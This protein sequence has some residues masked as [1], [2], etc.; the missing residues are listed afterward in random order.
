M[1]TTTKKPSSRAKTKTSKAKANKSTNSSKRSSAAKATSNVKSVKKTIDKTVEI[2][3]VNS[4]SRKKT[5]SKS[6]NNF[7]SNLWTASLGR[8]RS[9]NLMAAGLFLIL[10]VVA[11]A[12]MNTTSEQLTVGYLAKD[13]LASADQTVFTPAV[14]VIYDL[15]IRWLVVA[16]TLLSAVLP[17]LYLSKLE[18]NYQEYLAK[19]RMVPFRWIDYGVIGGLMVAITALLSGVSDLFVLKLLAGTVLVASLANLIAE[20]QNN[21]AA[22]PV[23][24]AYLVGLLAGILPMIVIAG[25]AVSTIVYGMIRSPWYVYALYAVL[26]VSFV[27]VMM[28]LWRQFGRAKDWSNYLAVER[29][30]LVISTVSKA[31]FAIILIVGLRS[32]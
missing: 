22:R 14:K 27:L 5:A 19:T 2:R 13:V 21:A 25:Y 3:S 11:G 8:I 28:N 1:A 31:A 20:R 23:R 18:N 12:V 16:V 7:L 4:G 26:V 32:V 15:E 10:A 17:L 30:Y 24:G 6:N 9:L 29:N